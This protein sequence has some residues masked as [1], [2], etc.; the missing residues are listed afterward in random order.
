MLARASGMYYETPEG[1]KILDGVAGLWC[2]NAGHGRQEITRGRGRAARGHG[3]RAAVPDG[4][5]GRLRARQRRGA[6]R[7]RGARPR[8]LHQLGLRVGRHRAQ[9]RAGVSPRERRRRARAVVR[10]RA[11]LSRRGL[12]RHQRRRHGG[13]SQG[14]AGGDDPGRRSPARTRTTSSATRSRA[15]CPRTARSSP[16]I[17][18]GWWRCTMPRPSPRS[19]SSPSPAPPAW[20]CRRRAIS[21]ACAR[22][23]TSTASC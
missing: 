22:S 19:S 2:V 11:R 12:R 21:S 18:S 14:V 23:A 7:A 9:D 5:S 20:C 8:V 15:A 13:Q 16:T 1:R 17:S 6:H 10:P 3:L 4:P